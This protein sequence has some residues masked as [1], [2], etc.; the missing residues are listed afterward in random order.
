MLSTPINAIDIAKKIISED[1]ICIVPNEVI[2]MAHK[3][4]EQG[5]LIRSLNEQIHTLNN[6]AKINGKLIE[7]LTNTFRK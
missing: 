1:C 3:I 6:L 4:L 7:I 5:V 2:I